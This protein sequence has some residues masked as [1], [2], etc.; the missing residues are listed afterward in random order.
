MPQ[1]MTENNFDK[2]WMKI[3]NATKVVSES[4]KKDSIVE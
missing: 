1:T 4:G 3:K 2:L